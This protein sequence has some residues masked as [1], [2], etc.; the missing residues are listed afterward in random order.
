[1]GKISRQPT[2]IQKSTHNSRLNMGHIRWSTYQLRKEKNIKRAIKVSAKIQGGIKQSIFNTLLLTY[3]QKIDTL[4]NRSHQEVDWTALWL[5]TKKS[6]H[7]EQRL[8][9]ILSYEDLSTFQVM[10]KMLVC[11]SASCPRKCDHSNKYLTHI[12]QCNKVDNTW[13][14]LEKSPSSLGLTQQSGTSLIIGRYTRHIL[15]A[16]GMTL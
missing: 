11:P 13:D 15:L 9:E 7:L 5:A 6:S 2:E 8:V 14:K 4:H 12:F 3:W 16:E 1:M 10:Y